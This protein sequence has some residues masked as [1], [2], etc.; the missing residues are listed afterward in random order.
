M[1]I[2]HLENLTLGHDGIGNIQSGVLPLNRLVHFNSIA[3]PVVA[4]SGETELQSAK[5]VGD[6]FE[7]IDKTVRK[8]VSGIYAPLR[9]SAVMR[10]VK[11]A[12]GDQIPE[13]RVT[14]F[15]IHLHTQSNFA[16]LETTF[17]H[18]LELFKSLLDRSITVN[19]SSTGSSIFTSTMSGNF[20]SSTLAGIGLQKVIK[21]HKNIDDALMEHS[22]P[23]SI[24]S[25]TY[26]SLLDKFDSQIVEFLEVVA[27]VGDLEGL[28]PKPSHSLQNRGEVFLFF[29]LIP[30]EEG[31]YTSKGLCHDLL[32]I[33]PLGWCHHIAN[34]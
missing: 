17:L 15:Q 24:R 33:V 1:F 18:H 22:Q 5:R 8:V 23:V 10:C 32:A 30:K 25:E 20:I 14:I 3:E 4:F 2:D 13:L 7:G 34:K 19:T 31:K 12:I 26:Q 21:E 11:N 16:F 27:G 9:T 28:K 6:V 29:S